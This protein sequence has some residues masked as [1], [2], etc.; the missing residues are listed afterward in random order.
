MVAEANTAVTSDTA[1]TDAA[2]PR[3]VKRKRDT[4]DDSG[5]GLGLPAPTPARNLT[6]MTWTR[7]PLPPSWWRSLPRKLRAFSGGVSKAWGTRGCFVPSSTC[8]SFGVLGGGTGGTG[9]MG[10]LFSDIPGN[11]AQWAL[12]SSLSEGHCPLDSMILMSGPV[13]VSRWLSLVWI[14]PSCRR[15]GAGLGVLVETWVIFQL[16]PTES[17][18]SSGC[19]FSRGALVSPVSY[20]E[21]GS[22]PR[23]SRDHLTASLK[24]IPAQDSQLRL[25][26]G[27][28]RSS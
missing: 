13:L 27:G 3:G 2:G 16:P 26:I 25:G 10:Y 17:V 1:V 14:P 5:R 11:E 23:E 9:V 19:P 6:R 22:H 7:E 15:H 28:S 24:S 21:P 20:V 18:P 12:C 4:A 8:L